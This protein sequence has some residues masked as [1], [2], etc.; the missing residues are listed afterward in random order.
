MDERSQNL[1]LELKRLHSDQ[2]T[3]NFTVLDFLGAFGSPVE[4]TAYAKLFWPDF[5]EVDGMLLRSD[6][7]EDESDVERARD[8]LQ[9]WNGDL[10]KTECSFNRLE[11]PSGIFGKR[12]GVSSDTTDD[13]LAQLLVEMWGARLCQTYSDR[14]FSVK[15]ER[16]PNGDRSVTFCQVRVRGQA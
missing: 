15:L 16:V 3:T 11:V 4:A 14:K 8:A 5:V 1:V 6:V 13:Q 10:E 2:D 12:A 7:I 9:K